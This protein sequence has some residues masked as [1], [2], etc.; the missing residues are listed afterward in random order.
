M[1]RT[2]SYPLSGLFLI[3][4]TGTVLFLTFNQ[5]NP[6]WPS[7]Q[8]LYESRGGYLAET[9]RDFLFTAILNLFQ[10]LGVEYWVF[11]LI[12]D[13]FF[14]IFI[15][16]LFAGRVFK[17]DK[18]LVWYGFVTLAIFTLF[19]IRSTVIIRE[20]IAL[21][22]FLVAVSY[23]Y[24]RD[25]SESENS[26]FRWM[27]VLF[28]TGSVL[29]HSGMAA[30]ALLLVL[31]A[32]IDYTVINVSIYAVGV[33]LTVV[34]AFLVLFFLLGNL[35]VISEW[36]FGDRELV[37]PDLGLAQILLWTAYGF[38]SWWL[39]Q[40]FWNSRSEGLY[41]SNTAFYLVILSGPLLVIN[42]LLIVALLF[43][44]FP[45]VFINSFIRHFH[46][47]V[48]LLLLF[49]AFRKERSV[50]FVLVCFFVLV[51]QVRAFFVALPV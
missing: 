34:A 50:V 42:L 41:N 14:L 19:F 6:D 29:V 7:Y 39:L 25:L 10:S 22:L 26:Y 11:R 44:N 31:A 38:V 16:R 51:D 1:I 8:S 17:Y 9:N 24:N 27:T 36:R 12:L 13:I 40:R 45:T 43:L 5:F 21:C 2:L 30:L 28:A 47:L 3:A 37:L 46:L 48:S 4:L 33:F 23:L 35:A 18:D 32:W 15:L 49:L 20:G